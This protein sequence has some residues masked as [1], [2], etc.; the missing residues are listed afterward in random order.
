MSPGYALGGGQDELEFHLSTVGEN[1]ENLKA[2]VR[3][4]RSVRPDAPI[5]FTVSPVPL[6][7]TFT[8]QDVFVANMESKSTLRVAAAEVCRSFEGVHYFPSYEVCTA[9]GDVYEADGRHIKRHV[10]QSIVKLFLAQFTSQAPD[11][12]QRVPEPIAVEP[13]PFAGPRPS[14]TFA[15]TATDELLDKMRPSALRSKT[16][17]AA[18]T[19]AA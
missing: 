2:T 8:Q 16:A 17:G 3:L 14:L 12:E 15:V 10:V 4:I 13:D 18:K 5:V 19:S 9:I 11:Q 7:A 1:F 6:T